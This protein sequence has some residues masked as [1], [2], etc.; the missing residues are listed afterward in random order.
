MAKS[1]PRFQGGFVMRYRKMLDSEAYRSLSCE[2][3]CLLEEFQRIYHPNHNGKLSI[4]TRK[5]KELLGVSEPT[6]GQAF[7][8][9]AS[10]GFIALTRNELWQERKARQWRLTFEPSAGHQPTDEWMRWDPLAPYSVPGRCNKSRRKKQ[11]Q[12]CSRNE[13]SLP[14]IFEQPSPFGKV[15]H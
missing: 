6:A 9:L 7:Y 11:G 1:K 14:R 2:A 13:D 8:E 10:C 5:A 15:R 12:N 4:S 3:R